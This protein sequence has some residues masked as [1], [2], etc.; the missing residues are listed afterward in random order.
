M[1]QRTRPG[2]AARFS[3]K[4][5]HIHRSVTIQQSLWEGYSERYLT[6]ISWQDTNVSRLELSPHVVVWDEVP[7]EQ[8]RFPLYLIQSV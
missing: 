3:R 4:G 7:L 2:L 8:S 6:A 5:L 1:N